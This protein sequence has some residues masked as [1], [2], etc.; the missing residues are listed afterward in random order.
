WR[1]ESSFVIALDCIVEFLEGELDV[2]EFF[3]PEVMLLVCEPSVHLLVFGSFI[4]SD[5]VFDF[6]INTIVSDGLDGKLPHLDLVP[7]EIRVLEVELLHND[8]FSAR[9][10][11]APLAFALRDLRRGST[12]AGR[13]GRVDGPPALSLRA[14][15]PRPRVAAQGLPAARRSALTALTALLAPLARDPDVD[16]LGQRQPAKARD[17]DPGEGDA[18]AQRGETDASAGLGLRGEFGAL[19]RLGAAGGTLGG[20]ALR[21]GALW[22]L[23]AADG[24]PGLEAEVLERVV[25]RVSVFERDDT[26]VGCDGGYVSPFRG[27]VARE[28]DASVDDRR[29]VR[30][31]GAFRDGISRVVDRDDRWRRGGGHGGDAQRN[32]DEGG[33]LA[34][35]SGENHGYIGAGSQREYCE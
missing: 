17:L 9:A 10:G 25:V 13:A 30:C 1:E 29:R 19:R 12:A 35:G 21:D 18:D 32:E 34:L 22:G 5:H 24:T 15:R 23:G 7:D 31:E 2:V 33:E 27:V 3:R 26:R 14:G 20:G 16:V 11:R 4:I 8:H 6:H 28:H